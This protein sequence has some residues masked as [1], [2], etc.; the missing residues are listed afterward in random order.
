MVRK[1]WVEH[2]LARTYI[3]LQ[4]NLPPSCHPAFARKYDLRLKGIRH[5]SEKENFVA[6]TRDGKPLTLTSSDQEAMTRILEELGIKRTPSEFRTNGYTIT[7]LV[8]YSKNTQRML[9]KEA[10]RLTEKDSEFH[11]D[12]GTR[13]KTFFEWANKW[14]ERFKRK[15][16]RMP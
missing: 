6:T 14:K 7:P 12:R 9:E 11:T 13:A 1:K 5:P 10:E 8:R 15:F 2:P 16:K 4:F 3:F